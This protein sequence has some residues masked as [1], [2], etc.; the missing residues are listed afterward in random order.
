LISVR[1]ALAISFLERYLSIMVAL[2][3]NMLLA[4]LL[5]PEQIGMYSVTLAVIGIAHVLREFG[6]GNFLIQ[7]KDLNDD[8]V[9]TAFT[10][11]LAIGGTLAVAIYVAAPW[12]AGFYDAPDMAGLLRIVAMNF[13]VLPFCSI[14]LSLL[15]RDMKFKALL[16]VNLGGLLAGTAVTLTLAWQGWGPT[17]MAV[18]AV[19]S[20]TASGVGAWWARGRPAPMRPGW[21]EWRT[22]LNF[23]GQSVVTGLVTTVSMDANDLVV[24][25][26][27]GFGPVAFLSRAQGL[28]NLFHRDVMGAVRNVAMPA[29]AA[30][31]RGGQDVAAR[32]RHSVQLLAVMAWAF[33]GLI[34]IYALEVIRLLFGNQWDVAAALVPWFA[35]AGV[36]SML[37]NLV[38]TMIIAVGRF[39]LVTRVEL[40]VQP[41][42][43]VLIVAAAVWWESMVAV[44]AAYLSATL[45]AAP[46][47]LYAGAKAVPGLLGGL[48]R[49]LAASG[50]VA[51]AVLLPA[52]LHGMLRG[53][54]EGMTLPLPEVAGCI[55]VGIAFGLWVAERMDHPITKE[56]LYR[57]LRQRLLPS[58]AAGT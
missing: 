32:F 23:G 44:A 2:G 9:R 24:G 8:H 53:R 4:R 26:V 20:N 14:S 46:V 12:V 41:L 47:F 51:S 3:S 39:E 35:L 18:G 19:V 38:P 42:R 10:L 37:V 7:Q 55:L 22:V 27:L 25:K 52:A 56:P 1:R 21:K 43:L 31:H 57:R 34:A 50:M 15:R 17:S 40:V 49:Q 16:Y 13:L 5:T 6:V 36:V 45:I 33:Y 48:A 29:F 28:M 30:A 11:A 58:S 54:A